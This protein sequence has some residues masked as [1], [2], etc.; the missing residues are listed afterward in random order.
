MVLQF[1]TTDLTLLGSVPY[2]G[3]SS[4]DLAATPSIGLVL[5]ASSSLTH[6]VLAQLPAWRMAVQQRHGVAPPDG[7]LDP[8]LAESYQTYM[9]RRGSLM[10]AEGRKLL[11]DMYRAELDAAYTDL[12]VEEP[13]PT[14]GAPDGQRARG[15][16]TILLGLPGSGVTG[17]AKQVLRFAVGDQEGRVKAESWAYAP[18]VLPIPTGPVS[19]RTYLAPVS[20]SLMQALEAGAQEGQDKT[21][22][23]LLAVCGAVSLPALCIY[24]AQHHG[25]DVTIMSASACLSLETLFETP[26][27]QE[28]KQ[29]HQQHLSHPPEK[30]WLPGLWDQTTEGWCSSV[31]IVDAEST[32]KGGDSSVLG[33]VLHRLRLINRHAVVLRANRGCL[34]PEVLSELLTRD[35][36]TTRD[37]EALRCKALCPSWRALDPGLLAG[38]APSVPGT[39]GL[40]PEAGPFDLRRLTACLRELF[41]EASMPTLDVT[42]RAKAQGDMSQNGA[43]G[44]TSGVR[45]AAELAK[46]KVLE[47]QMA[48]DE[49]GELQ[50]NLKSWRAERRALFKVS[51]WAGTDRSTAGSEWTR[52]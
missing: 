43:E 52:R 37:A 40:L 5:P 20:T 50:V 6:A 21:Q 35:K 47:E 44:G 46:A 33:R 11:E 38:P 4:V 17:L 51:E 48:A 16:V 25:S 9:R 7:V 29:T 24:L 10:A 15:L 49:E 14:P 41:P 13:R 26:A 32:V 3:C 19:T 18:V 31:V 22:R 27:T 30:S 28:Q 23:V 1:R 42:S 36:Y 45:R 34:E 2:S 39:H 8:D 12:I